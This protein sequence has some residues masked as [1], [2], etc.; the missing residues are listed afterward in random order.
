MAILGGLRKSDPLNPHQQLYFDL[1]I[2]VDADTPE[3]VEGFLD[4][5]DPEQQ[6]RL[7]TDM[8][9]TLAGLMQAQA[10]D[11]GD[12]SQQIAA[13]WRTRFID[14]ILPQMGESAAEWELCAGAVIDSIPAFLAREEEIPA[15][16]ADAFTKVEDVTELLLAAAHLVAGMVQVNG[17][18]E[19]KRHQFFRQFARKV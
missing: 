3:A 13:R 9:G 10:E 4:R 2:A 16:L 8:M 12:S 6:S 5:T 18:S 19:R 11:S 15:P 1:L 17:F 7:L 14:A